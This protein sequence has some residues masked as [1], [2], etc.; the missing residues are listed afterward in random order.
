VIAEQAHCRVAEA[1]QA[2]QH[3]ERPRPAVDEVAEDDEAVARRREADL[4][5][6]PLERVGAALEIADQMDHASILLRFAGP[7]RS[8]ARLRRRAWTSRCWPS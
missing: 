5:E 1:A 8:A 6:Q 3:R 2:P 4:G 7:T